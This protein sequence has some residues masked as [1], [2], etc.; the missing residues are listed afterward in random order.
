MSKNLS[1]SPLVNLKNLRDLCLTEDFSE[2][3]ITL[4]QVGK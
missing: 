2:R 1:N 4:P 3:E